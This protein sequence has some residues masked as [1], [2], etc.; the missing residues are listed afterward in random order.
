VHHSLS[1]EL[2]KKK[3]EN[4]VQQQTYAVAELKNSDNQTKRTKNMKKHNAG[5][6][7]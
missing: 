7:F 1:S 5:Y 3:H 4:Q 6:I 2:F